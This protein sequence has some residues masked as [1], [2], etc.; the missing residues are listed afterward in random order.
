MLVFIAARH[1]I[2]HDAIE[3]TC[4]HVLAL[5]VDVAAGNTIVEDAFGDFQFGTLL[6]HR[7]QQLRHFQVGLRSDVV[8]EIE[9]AQANQHRYDDK[10]AECLHERD[11][12]GLNSCEFAAFTEVSEGDERR[13]QDGQRQCLRHK[14]QAHVPE[15]L[16]HDFQRDALS[17][18]LID[19]TPQKLHHQYKLA[20]EEC[21]EKQQ[22][23]LPGYE[24][25]EFLD[26]KHLN[27]QR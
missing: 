24:Y 11:A 3:H 6:L 4:L 18:E 25:V 2:D 19:E 8:L 10:R 14:H 23:K 27:V 7:H 1:A 16:G 20:D 9:R 26:S 21:A 12:C 15:K 17:D 13:K 22:P 5:H